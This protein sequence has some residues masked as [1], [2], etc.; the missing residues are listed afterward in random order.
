MIVALW[1]CR[2]GKNGDSENIPPP[3]SNLK[4][5]A[6]LNLEPT[7]TA[8]VLIT[9]IELTKPQVEP[10]VA[11]IGEVAPN[12][13]LTSTG[14]R[15]FELESIFGRKPA[16]ISLHTIFSEY[17][18]LDL[19]M[20]I[21]LQ[22]KFKDRIE[23]ASVAFSSNFQREYDY[24]PLYVANED[25]YGKYGSVS[26]QYYFIDEGG[27][28]MLRRQDVNEDTLEM[29]VKTILDISKKGISDSHEFSLPF[30]LN[31]EMSVE[32]VRQ[33]P[34]LPYAEQHFFADLVVLGAKGY[35]DKEELFEI[36]DLLRKVTSNREF[37][38]RPP[39]DDAIM[40]LDP[41]VTAGRKLLEIYCRNPN[42][43]TLDVLSKMASGVYF[44]ILDEIEKGMVDID[45]WKTMR[46][47]FDPSC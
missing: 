2:G 31:P 17:P 27:R 4:T 30:E 8:E 19:G 33:D 14:G 47:N 32:V 46:I 18:D 6:T 11:T 38:G 12:V 9:P 40:Y 43:D 41:F 7:E 20:E 35:L 37:Y 1:A 13:R 34:L 39:N 26:P 15:E 3:E 22:E 24:F 36:S 10:Q 25:F 45:Y 16:V 28:F 21:K 23:I 44:Q 42:Q 5:T 29:L